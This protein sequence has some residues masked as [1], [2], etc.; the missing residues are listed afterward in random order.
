M[1]PQRFETAPEKPT[2]P[3]ALA[4]QRR[5]PY[6]FGLMDTQRCSLCD[7]NATETLRL[8]PL[9]ARA[10]RACTGVLGRMIQDAPARLAQVWP[11][12]LERDGEEPEPRV[13]LPDGRSVELRE[14]TAELKRELSLEQRAQL[15]T[16]LGELGLERE[17]LLEAAFVL[18][19]GAPPPLA[20]LAV[21]ALF[22]EGRA[23]P[24]AVAVLRKYLLPS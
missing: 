14:R 3:G 12:L 22:S 5:R 17:Q 6:L 15:V 10:C 19:A 7:R 4:P 16:L 11:M 2:A 18:F 8:G 9:D 1:V 23:A 21:D 24:T 20:Q 13:R